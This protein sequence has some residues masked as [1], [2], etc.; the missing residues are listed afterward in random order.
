MVKQHKFE[1]TYITSSG[2]KITR[3]DFI[4][5]HSAKASLNRQIAKYNEKLSGGKYIYDDG[6]VTSISELRKAGVPIDFLITEKKYNI[7]KIKSK[8]ELD[9]FIAEARSGAK[10]DYIVDYKMNAY[11]DNYEKALLRA[12]DDKAKNV[13]EVLNSLTPEQRRK[14]FASYEIF[15]IK[16]PY[17]Y[18][19]AFDLY[20][21]L[22]KEAIKDVPKEWFI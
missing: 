17:E 11:I 7:G 5:F 10:L 4:A 9:I 15:N 18:K 8:K 13:I 2:L 12:F 6:T 19:N 16:K 21:E 1:T 22:I 20:T 14:L 3:S